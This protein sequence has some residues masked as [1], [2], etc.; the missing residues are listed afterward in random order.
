MATVIAPA[1]N[2]APVEMSSSPAIIRKPTGMAMIP[3]SEAKFTQV[4]MPGTD[5]KLRLK[6]KIA[7][8]MKTTT[9]PM[10]AP[11]AGLRKKAAREKP[12]EAGSVVLDEVVSVM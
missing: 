6:P 3:T 12:S 7:N 4:V 10:K 8:T 9:K 2:T 1:G 5:R 11:A